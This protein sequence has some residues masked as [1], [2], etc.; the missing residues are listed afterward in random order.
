MSASATPEWRAQEYDVAE[1]TGL[2]EGEFTGVC[3]VLL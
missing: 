1:S 3:R 2:C